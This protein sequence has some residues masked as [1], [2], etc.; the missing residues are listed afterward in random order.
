[1][2]VTFRKTS[3][4]ALLTTCSLV[5]VSHAEDVEQ[6]R[7]S[8][9]LVLGTIHHNHE[10]NPNYTFTDVVRVLT[11]FQPDLIGVEIRPQDF[12]REPYLSEMMIGTIW[13]T[14]HGKKVYP[15]DWWTDDAVRRTRDS[16]SK[17][18][19]YI[20]KEKKLN[21]L[22]KA[23]PVIAAFG[24]LGAIGLLSHHPTT[25][26]DPHHE[27]VRNRSLAFV[28]VPSEHRSSSRQL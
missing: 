28:P 3:W 9:V 18:P 13:G 20:L 12:R 19:E 16:L 10:K 27:V 25:L 5:L 24:K 23:S 7:K 1:M 6:A 17:L 2:N 22:E 4:F 8:Q 26:E 21:S 14:T 15:I 11:V